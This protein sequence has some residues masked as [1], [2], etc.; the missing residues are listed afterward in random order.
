MNKNINIKNNIL[1]LS[2]LNKSNLKIKEEYENIYDPNIFQ[3][4]KKLNSLFYD[5]I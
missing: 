4:S 3:F 2:Y 1:K 5:R